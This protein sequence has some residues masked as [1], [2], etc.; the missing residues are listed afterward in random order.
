MRMQRMQLKHLLRIQA[1]NFSA[2]LSYPELSN[3]EME[4]VEGTIRA[5]VMVTSESRGPTI[6]LHTC[7]RCG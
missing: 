7:H 6:L 5:T 1:I 3:C 4:S 2:H